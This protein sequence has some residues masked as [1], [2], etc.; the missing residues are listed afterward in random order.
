VLFLFF[1]AEF[2][3]PEELADYGEFLFFFDDFGSGRYGAEFGVEKDLF[4]ERGLGN[5]L[6]FPSVASAVAA[7]SVVTATSGGASGTGKVG[8]GDLEAVEEQ[9]GALGVDFIA[10][11]AAEDLADGRL[12]RGTVFGVGQVEGGPTATALA[13]VG[14]RAPGGVVVVAE[15]FVAEARA[16]AAAS[17]G[18]DVAALILFD[19]VLHVVSCPPA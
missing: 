13:R 10:G 9:T 14:D 7:T 17:F 18:E 5:V 19:F 4:D 15:L 6:F 8:A 11:D 12:D 16:G 3:V 2:Y 1:T